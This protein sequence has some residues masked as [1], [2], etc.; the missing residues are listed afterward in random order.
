[1][2]QSG[3]GS[4]FCSEIADG[5]LLFTYIHREEGKS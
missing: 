4:T 1:M 5:R 3:A 2:F